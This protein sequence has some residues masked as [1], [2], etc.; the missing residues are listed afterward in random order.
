MY[1]GGNNYESVRG[2]SLL[3]VA[4][5]GGEAVVVVAAD[6]VIPQPHVSGNGLLFGV[7]NVDVVVCVV[8][9]VNHAMIV[10]RKKKAA[11]SQCRQL[12]GYLMAKL[13][14]VVGSIKRNMIIMFSFTISKLVGKE[15][16]MFLGVTQR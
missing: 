2:S 4:A 3:H 8:V 14:K 10:T 6:V 16:K 7:A 5:I 9:V 15:L 11:A 1:F 12:F 13:E